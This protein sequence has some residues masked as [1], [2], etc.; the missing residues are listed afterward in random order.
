LSLSPSM[1]GFHVC[2]M[3]G[4]ATGLANGT[5]LCLVLTA[6]F[7]THTTHTQL[8]IYTRTHTIYIDKHAHAHN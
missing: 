8:Y 5:L 1:L 6:K 7:S 3:V 2:S 4:E